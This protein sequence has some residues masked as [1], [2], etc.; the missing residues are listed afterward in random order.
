M[1]KRQKRVL[2]ALGWYDYRLHRGIERYA[3]EHEWN[4]SANLAREKVIPWGCTFSEISFEKQSNRQSHHEVLPG[5]EEALISFGEKNVSLVTSAA[6]LRTIPC[7]HPRT[8][9]QTRRR[10]W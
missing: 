7:G 1:R 9:A 10:F 5:R 4:L 3:L 6:A 2:V 8:C